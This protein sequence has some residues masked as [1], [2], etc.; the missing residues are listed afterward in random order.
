MAPEV[1]CAA[2]NRG[3]LHKHKHFKPSLNS[4]LI[5]I[6]Q[7]LINNMFHLHVISCACTDFVCDSGQASLHYALYT[8]ARLDMVQW[9]FVCI[10]PAGG[11][12]GVPNCS[13]WF[14]PSCTSTIHA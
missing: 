8:C 3:P 12:P 6:S 5:I 10:H 2:F 1:E 7:M 9:S 13:V 4:G 14:T 11:E